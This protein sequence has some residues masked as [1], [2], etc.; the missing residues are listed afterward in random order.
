MGTVF[1]TPYGG[2]F[3]APS[4]PTREHSLT[5]S[6]ITC[7]IS[8]VLLKGLKTTNPP[9]ILSIFA[10][11][12]NNLL[13]YKNNV[14]I[15]DETIISWGGGGG[16]GGACDFLNH[17]ILSKM[18]LQSGF[19]NSLRLRRRELIFRDLPFN[20]MYNMGYFHGYGKNLLFV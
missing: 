13:C 16:G 3:F 10:C 18:M 8:K 7:C 6:P 20:I 9:L 4:T 5:K 15:F 17:E 14:S 11:R 19:H 12:K 2:D 1:G